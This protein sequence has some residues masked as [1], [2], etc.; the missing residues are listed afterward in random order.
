MGLGFT[1]KSSMCYSQ[2]DSYTPSVCA[3]VCSLGCRLRLL[4][5]AL[6]FVLFNQCYC[7]GALA[8]SVPKYIC[9]LNT[10]SAIPDFFFHMYNHLSSI[11][12]LTSGFSLQFSWSVV[13]YGVF[14]F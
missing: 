14:W 7:R 8:L 6:S 9:I 4:C 1:L 10:A 12:I 2:R 11:M 13:G 3:H 5:L